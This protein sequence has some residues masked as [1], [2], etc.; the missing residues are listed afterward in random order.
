MASLQYGDTIKFDTAKPFQLNSV[1]DVVPIKFDT[2]NEQWVVCAQNKAT[3]MLIVANMSTDIDTHNVEYIMIEIGKCNNL[4][5][6]AD[7]IVD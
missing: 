4:Y 7:A 1:I 3:H 5:L 2:I 6:L